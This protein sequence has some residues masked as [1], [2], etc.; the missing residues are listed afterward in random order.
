MILKEGWLNDQF[1]KV[2]KEISEWSPW[3]KELS[4][5][6]KTIEKVVGEPIEQIRKTT[7]SERRRRIEAKFGKKMKIGDCSPVLI[8]SEEI[9]KDLDKILKGKIDD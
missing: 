7:I 4:G 2:D 1:E 6:E 3:M 8:S 9:N 5:F